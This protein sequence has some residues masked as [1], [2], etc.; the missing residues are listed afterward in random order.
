[1]V[2]QDIAK[3]IKDKI[4]GYL[5]SV[6]DPLPTEVQ[7]AQH[8]SVS[9]NT[10]RKALALLEHDGMIERKHGSGTFVKQKN[11]IA[12][13]NHMNSLSEIAKKSG[14]EVKSQII[15][16]EVQEAT[17]L[18]S[19]ELKIMPQDPV[20]YIKRLRLI[21]D[22]PIQLEE[23]WLSVNRFPALTI[24]HMKNSKFFYIENECNIKIIGTFETFSPV[25]PTP[26]VASILHTSIIDPILKIQTQ[27]VDEK[28]EPIDYS[29]LY[30]NIFEFQVKYFLPRQ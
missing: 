19:A 4:N 26:E 25:F 28:Y 17:Q 16:F 23:T 20:Y 5:Y 15:K 7:L 1:M 8:Y 11:F 9:R 13:V 30:S 14:K 6:G 3:K 22:K 12:H 21:D 29:I 18:I 27:A 2:F 10:I 24:S